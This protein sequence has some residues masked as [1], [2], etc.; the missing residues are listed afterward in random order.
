MKRKAGEREEKR[1]RIRAEFG[2]SDPEFANPLLGIRTAGSRNCGGAPGGRLGSRS[3]R[4]LRSRASAAVRGRVSTTYSRPR[5]GSGPGSR[6]AMG[7]Y[8]CLLLL[9]RFLDRHKIRTK[10]HPTPLITYIPHPSPPLLLGLIT[11]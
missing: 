6:G 1:N 4:A 2:Q 7:V 10:P 3:R 5:P 8:Y 9:I 11:T